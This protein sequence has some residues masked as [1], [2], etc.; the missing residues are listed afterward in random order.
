MDVRFS[1]T[2]FVVQVATMPGSSAT[3]RA[4]TRPARGRSNCP[5]SHRTNPRDCESGIPA[6]SK[7][8]ATG[9]AVSSGLRS[10]AAASQRN[11]AKTI[12]SGFRSTA[13]IRA[14][15]HDYASKP[16]SIR[17]LH[18]I[19]EMSQTQT[20]PKSDKVQ[21]RKTNFTKNA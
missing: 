11:F 3:R 10:T 14:Q 8:T 18:T 4:A 19:H 12:C 7:L 9:N 20:T 6:T 15:A 16:P 2:R 17:S 5:T 21:K 13:L 1:A